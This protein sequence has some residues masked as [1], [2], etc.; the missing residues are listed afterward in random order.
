M[1]KGWVGQQ[2]PSGAGSSWPGCHRDCQEPRLKRRETRC[3]RRKLFQGWNAWLSI[4]YFSSHI[5]TGSGSVPCRPNKVKPNVNH[6]NYLYKGVKAST[7]IL[8]PPHPLWSCRY[9]QD[10]DNIQWICFQLERWSDV[11]IQ[12]WPSFSCVGVSLCSNL[13]SSLSWTALG[14]GPFYIGRGI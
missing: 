9:R 3:C 8:H 14:I 7:H 12:H 13:L 10:L 11:H 5:C 1:P 2:S 4:S 6:K